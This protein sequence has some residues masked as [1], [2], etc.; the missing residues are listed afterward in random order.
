MVHVRKICVSL[1]KSEKIH[2]I[3]HIP[4]IRRDGA[5]Y[6]PQSTKADDD[7]RRAAREA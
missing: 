3:A 2:Y 7:R 1:L 6:E 5:R 4:L